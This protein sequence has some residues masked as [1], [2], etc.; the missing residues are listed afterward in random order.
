MF[1]LFGCT[2]R[3][4]SGSAEGAVSVKRS[5]RSMVCAAVVCLA[6]LPVGEA[7]ATGTSDPAPVGAVVF[8]NGDGNVT[9]IGDGNSAAGRD[10][11]VGSGHVAGVGHIAGTGHTVGSGLGSAAIVPSIRAN[12]GLVNDPPTGPGA[13]VVTANCPQGDTILDIRVDTNTDNTTGTQT[14]NQ[15][16]TGAPQQFTLNFVNDVSTGP[17]TVMTGMDLASGRVVDGSPGTWVIT[18]Y[19]N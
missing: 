6:S 17:L 12:Y 1:G 15:P 5:V 14:I 18:M 16:C 19:G 10:S 4:T 8:N 3:G 11:L 13:V 7:A 9:V 2:H